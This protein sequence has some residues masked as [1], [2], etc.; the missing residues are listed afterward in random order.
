VSFKSF[1]NF[2]HQIEIRIVPSSV[3]TIYVVHSLQIADLFNAQYIFQ[4]IPSLNPKI[5]RATG[6]GRS[7]A[8]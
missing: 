6:M 3:V 7:G 5:C 8:A 1:N 4:E 2:P